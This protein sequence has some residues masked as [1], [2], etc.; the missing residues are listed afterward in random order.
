MPLGAEGDFFLL[1]SVNVMCKV[2]EAALVEMPPK[3]PDVHTS[4]ICISVL[5]YYF[6]IRISAILF[7]MSSYESS[8][9]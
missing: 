6:V 1:L 8:A 3:A 9:A 2:S 4:G 7:V 5:F